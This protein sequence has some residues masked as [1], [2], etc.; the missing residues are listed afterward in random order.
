MIIDDE[1]GSIEALKWVLKNDFNIYA[2][3]NPRVAIQLVEKNYQH[4]DVIFLDLLMEGMSG[5]EFLQMVKS[6]SNNIEVVIVSACRNKD[7][8]LEAMR[9][10]AFDCVEKPFS[11]AEMEKTA[12]RAV[13]KRIENICIQKIINIVESSVGRFDGGQAD[14]V[15]SRIYCDDQSTFAHS[16]RVAQ[17]F[18]Q[19]ITRYLGN[20]D[21]AELSKMKTVAFLHDIGKIGVNID[22]LTKRGGLSEW[23]YEEVKRHP[24]IGYNILKRI[25]SIKY[26]LDMVLHHQE[27]YDG[28]GY[29]EKLKGEQISLY[30]RMLSIA[31]AFDAMTDSRPY[32]QGMNTETALA[33]L[34]GNAG[35]QFDAKLV[36]FFVDNLYNLTS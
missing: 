22:I 29:P 28:S 21:Q 9:E 17:V 27:R 34:K 24:R 33:E 36:D 15:I 20:V 4:I 8:I 18:A 16:R 2:F 7:L 35:T 19:M 32:R 12:D 6:L 13:Q 30:S 31:D 5:I 23:E 3:N 1:Q 25:D 26:D 10:G 14:S 11:V